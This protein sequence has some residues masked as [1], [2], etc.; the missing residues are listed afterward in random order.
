VA[1]GGLLGIIISWCMEDC[2]KAVTAVLSEVVKFGLAIKDYDE[3]KVGV[4]KEVG[5]VE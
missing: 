4:Y 1:V 2:K 3:L 5:H